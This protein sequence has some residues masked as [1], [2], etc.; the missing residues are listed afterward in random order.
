MP[1]YMTNLGNHKKSASA[2]WHRADIKAALEKRGLS[3]A[4]LARL[5]GYGRTSAAMA[6]ATPWPKMER[7]IA[8]AIG[9]PPQQIWP[10]RYHTDGTPKSR[11]GERIGYVASK[12][13]TGVEASNDDVTRGN[14][15][16]ARAR[17]THL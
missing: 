2:D 4:K 8:G 3:L 5:N 6:L 12:N 14:R 16:G 7:L 15:H 9:V 13:T 17:R 1:T 11:R 10:T